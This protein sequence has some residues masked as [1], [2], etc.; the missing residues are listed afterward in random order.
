VAVCEFEQ[1]ECSPCKNGCCVVA[2]RNLKDTRARDQREEVDVTII[3]RGMDH[4]SPF[5]NK[6]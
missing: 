6:R 5:F 1:G 4:L 2:A 3:D